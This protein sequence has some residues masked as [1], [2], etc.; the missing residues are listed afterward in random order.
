[1]F[2]NSKY[3]NQNCWS[4]MKSFCRLKEPNMVVIAP[5]KCTEHLGSLFSIVMGAIG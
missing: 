1:M 3:V 2:W 5:H 4:G